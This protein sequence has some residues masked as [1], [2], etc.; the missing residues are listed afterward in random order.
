MSDNLQEA[1]LKSF[2][3]MVSSVS[4][5]LPKE[6]KYIFYWNIP[7]MRETISVE[8]QVMEMNYHLYPTGIYYRKDEE[9]LRSNYLLFRR[10]SIHQVKNLLFEVEVL[11]GK[12]Q[13]FIDF[14]KNEKF[15]LLK[16]K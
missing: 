12:P 9:I 2:S 4:N 10:D 16:R 13:E 11:T 14:F 15:I 1:S 5:L 7:I 6:K 8:C 3:S